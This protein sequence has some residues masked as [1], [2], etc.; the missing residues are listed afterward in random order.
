MQRIN[1]HGNIKQEVKNMIS[2][3]GNR[4]SL[5]R[6]KQIHKPDLPKERWKVRH[7]TRSKRI[8]HSIKE[9]IAISEEMGYVWQKGGS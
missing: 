4:I 2:I 3:L 6:P 8:K 9:L 7:N 1:K 5:I